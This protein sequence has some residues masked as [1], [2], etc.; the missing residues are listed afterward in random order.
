M[1]RL[2]FITQHTVIIYRLAGGIGIIGTSVGARFHITAAFTG[3]DVATVSVAA[4]SAR[5]FYS[6]KTTQ[7]VSRVTR[8]ASYANAVDATGFTVVDIAKIFA[9]FAGAVFAVT[10]LRAGFRNFFKAL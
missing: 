4:V 6:F 2:F 10:S 3:S 7:A 9:F 8:F 1:F 5:F